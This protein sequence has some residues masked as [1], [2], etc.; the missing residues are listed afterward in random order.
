MSPDHLRHDAT[1]WS[2][3]VRSCGSTNWQGQNQRVRAQPHALCS[4]SGSGHSSWTP[5]A[6]TGPPGPEESGRTGEPRR[7]CSSSRSES[8]SGSRSRLFRLHAVPQSELT[9]N[10]H[11]PG[12]RTRT[13][14]CSFLPRAQLSKLRKSLE[15]RARP[16]VCRC[17]TSSHTPALPP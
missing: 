17:S 9:R 3:Q 1:S 5:S 14:L 15:T 12:L 10:A 2:Q 7:R 11:A 8:G 16:C 6:S 13:R 4:P